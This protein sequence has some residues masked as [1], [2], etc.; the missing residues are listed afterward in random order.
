MPE[1]RVTSLE[2]AVGRVL[3]TMCFAMVLGPADP[4]DAQLSLMYCAQLKFEGQYKGSLRIGLSHAGA[5]ALAAGFLGLEQVDEPQLMEFTR[6]LAN[7]VCGAVVSEFASGSLY[8]LSPPVPMS[9]E[10]FREADGQ[11]VDFTLE[12]GFLS[13]L[14]HTA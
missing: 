9:P 7:M 10:E 8:S 5:H 6:E 3:E 13:V 12:E 1:V 4:A 11:R 14:S 2:D